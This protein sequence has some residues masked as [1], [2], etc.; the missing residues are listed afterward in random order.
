MSDLYQKQ[1]FERADTSPD[2]NFYV[3][4]RF[5][6]HIDDR[7]IE[8]ITSFYEDYLVSG[9]AFLD[10]MS[11]WV[12]HLPV[13]IKFSEVVGLG[14]NNDELKANNR[15]DS[16]LVHNLNNTPEI[17]LASSSFD[18]AAIVV[19][20]QYLVKPYKVFQS[21][22]R[23]LKPGGQC[24]VMM[25]NR[26]FPSKA[27]YAFHVLNRSA[28]IALVQDYMVKGGFSKTEFIDRSPSGANPLWVVRGEKGLA[29]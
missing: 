4:P 21:I 20:V 9:S 19:S 11:S 24:I 27:I 22:Y 3:V 10:L 28:R 25:S 16:H 2:E 18:T 13:S 7:T 29:E 26:M 12:S 8:A 17:P 6:N 23:L 14:M 5:V 15:L 1:F